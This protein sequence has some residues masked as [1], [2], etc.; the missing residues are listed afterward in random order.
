M[1]TVA[2]QSSAVEALE[3]RLDPAEIDEE[4]LG[5]VT[6]LPEFLATTGELSTA[7]RAVLVDQ[8]LVLIEDLYVHLPLKRAM[9][10]VDPVQRLKLLRF[11]LEQLSERRFHDELI[12][13]FTGL[14][15]LH[16]NYNLP[17][18]YASKTAFLPFL[19]EEFFEGDERRYLVSKTFAGFS[20][21]TFKPGV[22]VTHWN[23]MPI[24]RAVEL[25]A[26]REAGSN[27]DARHARG[28]EGM[29]L[30]PMRSASP[31]D[32]EFVAIG[33]SDGHQDLAL[34]LNW[35]VFE[36]DPAPEAVDP[37]SAE[38]PAARS[39]G[40]DVKTE[41]VRRAKKALFAPKAVAAEQQVAAAQ[42]EGADEP[43]VDPA[44][45][46]T[47]PDV[48]S[49]RSVTTAAGTFGYI[50]IWTFS[51]KD[52]DAFLDEF[53]RILS[54][55]PA[56]GLILDVRGNGGGLITA[57]ER[58]LQILT[59]RPIEPAPFGFINTP[60]TLRL[61][62]KTAF[63]KE[64]RDSIAQAVEIG[65]TYSLGFPI[66]A[67]E[68]VNDRGQ[69]YEGPVVLVVDALC[70]S[71]TDI[72]AAGFQDNR[73]GTILGV[74][75]NTGAGGA[76]VWTHDLLLTQIALQE[77]PFKPLPN[78]ATFR[79]AV[80]RTTR[81]GDHA[82]VVIEDLG[83]KP[84]VVYP[85]TRN[86]LLNGNQDMIRAATDLLDAKPKYRLTV[87]VTRPN[88]PAGGVHVVC[89][90]QGVN[91]IDA[92]VDARPRLTVDVSGPET[93]FDLPAATGVLELRGFN[94]D[95]R[96]VVRREVL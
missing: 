79:V 66:D 39:L 50:R 44:T 13:I 5:A 34:V 54:L 48:F 86:D 61:A 53:L 82:G 85:L 46:S 12:R 6:S 33:Y 19:I 2:A 96:V 63:L 80:R 83:V 26:E 64:W 41:A 94:G 10:A 73:V 81:V 92:F 93:A 1:A 69:Q 91:R 74:S 27:D 58:L 15:D 55:L 68:D 8:A 16:T 30:R 28:L 87:Q 42:A 75:G 21:P 77:S 17:Q 18:P 84:D 35:Q 31:P 78:G 38:H 90:S 59:P 36:P 52:A 43:A 14:R 29:T 9:H 89:Q 3:A 57:G 62:Q 60:L 32:E 45:T 71:T 67:V 20:H 70:Y 7:E 4:K 23:G 51:V 40:I 37:N 24:D 25:N 49:F 76:N 72:F 22:V 95:E 88:G 11:R 47:M 56:D 65:T